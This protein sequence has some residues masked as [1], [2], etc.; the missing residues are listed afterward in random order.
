MWKIRT[1]QKIIS[2]N[3][4][5]EYS[6]AL[7]TF[8]NRIKFYVLMQKNELPK[9]IIQS[10]NNCTNLIAYYPSNRF[11]SFASSWFV[12]NNNKSKNWTTLTRRKKKQNKSKSELNSAWSFHW[13]ACSTIYAYRTSFH[14]HSHAY[15]NCP[16]LVF[17]KTVPWNWIYSPLFRLKKISTKKVNF[18]ERCWTLLTGGRCSEII[19][20][21]KGQF[22]TSKLWP[23]LTGGRYSEVIVSSGLTVF[24]DSCG[25]CQLYQDCNKHHSY[26]CR[27]VFW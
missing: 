3:L 23:L 12:S 16:I 8:W 13:P 5:L 26:I 4:N 1:F 21:L 14:F 19:Y 25:I 15:I 11:I 7:K 27:L 6:F 2:Y 20:V 18:K 22:W 9:P 10:L 17:E 24:T